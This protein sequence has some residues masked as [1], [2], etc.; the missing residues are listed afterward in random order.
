LP[1]VS[2]T[3]GCEAKYRS[4]AMASCF[5][6]SPLRLK[7]AAFI[8]LEGDFGVALSA[9]DNGM[10]WL[11]QDTRELVQYFA[12]FR[13][14]VDYGLQEAIE[15]QDCRIIELFRQFA[16]FALPKDFCYA[17][18]R[19]DIAFIDEAL[20][21][22]T[23]T[24]EL[25][26]EA[27]CWVLDVKTFKFLNKKWEPW[28]LWCVKNRIEVFED[29]YGLHDGMIA[30]LTPHYKRWLIKGT[31]WPLI[32][33]CYRN[34]ITTFKKITMAFLQDSKDSRR[35]FFIHVACCSID[36]TFEIEKDENVI[37]AYGEWAA[38]CVENLPILLNLAIE[39][40][41][42]SLV[43]YIIGK[44]Y[45]VKVSSL[46]TLFDNFIEE[47]PEGWRI[48]EPAPQ[49]REIF[50]LLKSV[51]DNLSFTGT[52]SSDPDMV[53]MWRKFST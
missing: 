26:N 25:L 46:E 20:K 50:D 27:L 15:Q 28:Y 45:D 37:Q 11:D 34:W 32:R 22:F 21:K 19:G 42:V 14:R 17:V 36:M 47:G 52:M 2:F 44:T 39:H 31:N 23:L 13:G 10:P 6:V 18:L 4:V 16:S 35:R 48:I 38:Q 12:E 41:F 40:G 29:C 43:R 53:E 5:A 9:D 51:K 1:T 3:R 49:M 7:T 24:T 8:A 33:H 30:L